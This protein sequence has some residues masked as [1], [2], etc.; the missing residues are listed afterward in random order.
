MLECNDRF[1]RSVQQTTRSLKASG[2][3]E[4]GGQCGRPIICTVKQWLTLSHGMET[5]HLEHLPCGWTGDRASVLHHMHPSWGLV[6][7]VKS[8]ASRSEPRSS[9]LPNMAVPQHALTPLA[10]QAL[11][12][13]ILHIH[14]PGTC[15]DP[16]H[17]FLIPLPCL[18]CICPLCMTSDQSPS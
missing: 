8:A 17:P 11:R 12:L 16:I 5:F 15:P 14:A 7:A 4:E 9:V 1:E 18:T 13:H 10:P 3:G 2:R 6:C